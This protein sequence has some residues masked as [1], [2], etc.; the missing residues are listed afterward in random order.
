VIFDREYHRTL[1]VC[2]CESYDELVHQ[3]ELNNIKHDVVLLEVN[4]GIGYVF[5]ESHGYKQYYK[6]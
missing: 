1:T 4:S 6:D 3:L 2:D 5:N